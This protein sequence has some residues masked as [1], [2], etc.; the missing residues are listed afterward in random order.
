MRFAGFRHRLSSMLSFLPAK[1]KGFISAVLFALNTVFWC[2]LI[3][4]LIPVK[5]LFPSKNVRD[6]SSRL[7]IK[8]AESWIGFNSFE[9]GLMHKITWEV[10]GITGL[11]RDRSYLVS[12][13]HQSWIDI[14]VLQHVF[15]R[16]IPFLRFFLKSQ[17]I[18]VPFLGGAWWALDFPF[19]KRYSKSY[20]EKHPEKR[21]QDLKTTRKACERFSGSKISVLNFLEGTRFTKEKHDRQKSPYR[22]LL[23]PKAGGVAFVLDAMGKQFHSFLDV[24]IFYPDGAVSLWGLFSG[25]LDRVR[26]H[27]EEIFIPPDI[28]N[29]MTDGKYFEDARVREKIQSWVREIW[30][31][32]DR[33]IEAF[34]S[35]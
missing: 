25:Q 7:M 21:G 28:L 1:L 14:V 19:M 22:N 30:E 3:F 33:T 13:N 23:L 5:L 4:L 27:V 2:S 24:T 17:L 11:S 34:K 18:Y 35:R 6:W 29:D 9:A 20:L 16:R 15:N 26:V 12:A 8:M 31:K 32:K 10:D